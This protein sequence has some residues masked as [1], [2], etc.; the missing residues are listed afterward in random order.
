MQTTH[1]T[2]GEIDDI[3]VTTRIRVIRSPRHQL[4][5]GLSLEELQRLGSHHYWAPIL[6]LPVPTDGDDVYPPIVTLDQYSG[7]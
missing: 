1:E 2:H 6:D 3:P 5:S 7:W 4:G